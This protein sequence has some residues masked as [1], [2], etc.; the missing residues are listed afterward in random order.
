[1]KINYWQPALN[2]TKRR[3]EKMKWKPNKRKVIIN[4]MS[5][6]VYFTSIKGQHIQKFINR[7][8]IVCHYQ[9]AVF[10]TRTITWIP[11]N[12]HISIKNS[13]WTVHTS[14]MHVLKLVDSFFERVRTIDY[15]FC[16]AKILNV[17][18]IDKSTY[19]VITDYIT[20]FI[21]ICIHIFFPKINK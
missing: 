18:N 12:I 21:G 2:V 16:F 7:I 9:K 3:K 10:I 13:H 1:M 19:C 15:C 14:S 4:N 11:F 5:I 8:I 20:S 17:N 6:N